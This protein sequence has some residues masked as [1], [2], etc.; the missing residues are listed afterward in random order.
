MPTVPQPEHIIRAYHRE[1]PSIT[2][3][4]LE[5]RWAYYQLAYTL[6]HSPDSSSVP[7][8][9]RRRFLHLGAL[10]DVLALRTQDPNLYE[11]ARDYGELLRAADGLDL[12][13]NPRNGLDHLR[14]Q[15]GLAHG[16]TNGAAL[17]VQAPT[18]PA[19]RCPLPSHRAAPWLVHQMCDTYTWAALSGSP[20]F[21]HI[22]V[23]DDRRRHLIT[24]GILLDWAASAAPAD[25]ATATA[26]A[27]AGHALRAFDG[28]PA[29]DD[30]GARTYLLDALRDLDDQDEDEYPHPLD[31]A[32]GCAGDGEVLTVLTWEHHGDGIYTPVHQEPIACL[33]TTTTEHAA[34]CATCD[35]HG[36]TY[37]RGYRDLCLDG[38]TPDDDRELTSP[39]RGD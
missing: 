34:D 37:T 11:A 27:Q 5:A 20:Q 30:H 26:A 7:T 10:C 21:P 12:H 17:V 6:E 25:T 35:G 13:D 3:L 23:T 8:L 24:R 19:L 29:L 28:R 9:R 4:L 36:Y 22:E 31:C 32:G 15:H 16:H 39:P 18:T 2:R 33:G 38:R 14:T 1:R